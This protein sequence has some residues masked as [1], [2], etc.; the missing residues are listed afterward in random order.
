MTNIT[1]PQC[2]GRTF[3]KVVRA[4]A[5]CY[6]ESPKN[7]LIVSTDN[8][9]RRELNI[10]VRQELKASGTAV[11]E[12]NSIYIFIQS[13]DMTDAERVYAIHADT[14]V[15]PDLLNSRFGYVS[16]SRAS[17]DATVFT[18]DIAKLAPQLSAD[19]SKTSAL[20]VGQAPTISQGIEML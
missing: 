12:D 20:E 6:I 19:V 18:N 16:I 4:I 17:H 14:S 8:A 9:F 7:T 15:H 13:Q 3:A 1:P 5:K 11:S 2:D 10:A